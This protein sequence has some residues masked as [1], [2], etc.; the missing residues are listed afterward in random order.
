MYWSK[1]FKMKRLVALKVGSGGVG[2]PECIV[3][4]NVSV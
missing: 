4:V 2:N 1:S 3:V